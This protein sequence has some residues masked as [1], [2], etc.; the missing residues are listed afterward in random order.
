MARALTSKHLKKV[1]SFCR[2]T[3]QN[4]FTYC[5]YYLRENTQIITVGNKEDTDCQLCLQRLRADVKEMCRHDWI[6]FVFEDAEPGKNYARRRFDL[7]NKCG[8]KINAKYF[9]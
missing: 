7:C 9:R 2:G 3:L 1:V 5:G 6:K 8:K 4:E